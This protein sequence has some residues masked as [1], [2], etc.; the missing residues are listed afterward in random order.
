MQYLKKLSYTGV[1]VPQ[2]QKPP[3]HQTVIIFDWDDTL[4]CTSY[5]N[6]RAGQQ[7]NRQDI[8]K[9]VQKHLTNIST[10]D[11][12]LL[13]MAMAHGETFIITNAMKGWVEYSARKYVPELLPTL[14]KVR[15][16]SARTAF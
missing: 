8:S 6:L 1:W 16:I 12:K 7:Q 15:I 5:L 10:T 13:E 3:Q 4:L 2:A 9:S 11:S 14:R